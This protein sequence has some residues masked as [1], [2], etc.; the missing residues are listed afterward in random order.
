MDFT[1]FYICCRKKELYTRYARLFVL[2]AIH[3]VVVLVT[4][5]ESVDVGVV[6]EAVVAVA[7]R[8]ALEIR[9]QSLLLVNFG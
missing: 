2:H 8:E 5:G 6:D 4:V 9:K 7:P 1:Y 3:L